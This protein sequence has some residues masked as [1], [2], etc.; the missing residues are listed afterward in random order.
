M[1]V[2]DWLTIPE[3][4]LRS[5]ARGGLFHDGLGTIGPIISQLEYYPHDVWLYLLANQWRRI[6]QEDAFMGRCGQVGDELGSRIVASRLIRD[7]MRL[8]FLMERE[9]APYIKWFGTAFS[10]L[11]CS[12]TL[13]PIFHQ[14]FDAQTWQDRQGHLVQGYEYV[15][16]LQNK[17]KITEPLKTK[18]IQFHNRPFLVTN[19]EAFAESIHREI[20][21][22]EVKALPKFLGSIDQYVDSTDVLSKTD[23][24]PRL[25]LMYD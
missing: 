1:S 21:D 5:L 14:I 6:F 12:E 13:T 10:K 7:L 22:P 9:Y 17:L 2:V 15:G 18:V 8:C 3:Q 19:G 25:K 20:K 11:K 23:K 24:Y 4:V 16:E